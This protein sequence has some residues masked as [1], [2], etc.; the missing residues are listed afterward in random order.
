MVKFM[1]PHP[2]SG[3]TLR[4]VARLKDIVFDSS[5]AA[6]LARFWVSALDD[7]D[8]A[9][10]DEEE[11][12]RLRGKGIFDVEDDPSVLLEPRTPGQPRI[13]CQLVPERKVAKNRMH[14]DLR[15][16]DLAAEVARLTALGATVL[17]D[18]GDLITLADP[19]GNEFCVVR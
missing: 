10:Y 12:E 2:P 3:R 11:L 17:A 8:I 9:P 15:A 5:H 7:Y 4:T 18:Y 6:S 16:D 1:R 19:Q 13:I 14:L